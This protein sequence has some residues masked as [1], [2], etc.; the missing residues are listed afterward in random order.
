MGS[1]DEWASLTSLVKEWFAACESELADKVGQ[2]EDP[3]W[4]LIAQDT[5]MRVKL[6]G[7]I[8]CRRTPSVAFRHSRD[9]LMDLEQQ[10]R[11]RFEKTNVREKR[12]KW[13]LLWDPGDDNEG[14]LELS[15]RMI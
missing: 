8:T 10:D 3:R 1:D 4:D 2:A 14:R 12:A 13:H 7:Q 9:R 5:P 11:C 6:G 15:W